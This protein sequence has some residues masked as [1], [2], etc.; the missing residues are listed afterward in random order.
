[1]ILAIA[2]AL[3]VASSATQSV[4]LGELLDRLGSGAH[5][6]PVLDFAGADGGDFAEVAVQIQADAATLHAVLPSST[7]LRGRRRAHDTDGFVL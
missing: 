7:A 6:W 5:P 4:G 2:S 1:M 3:L